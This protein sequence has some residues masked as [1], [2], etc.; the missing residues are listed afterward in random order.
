MAAILADLVL[1]V[2]VDPYAGLTVKI[3]QI[4][5]GLVWLLLQI[6][7]DRQDGLDQIV[8]ILVND[9]FVEVVVARQVFDDLLGVGKQVAAQHLLHDSASVHVEAQHLYL[10]KY[11][12]HN[13]LDIRAA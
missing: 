12:L 2:V 5:L 9:K 4:G 3:K 1:Q 11:A 7:A 10:M 6:R 13:E 8:S